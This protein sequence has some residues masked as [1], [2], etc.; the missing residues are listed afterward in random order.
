MKRLN[1]K[2]TFFL[3]SYPTFH[4]KPLTGLSREMCRE[5][6]PMPEVSLSES[7]PFGFHEALR[8]G[9]GVGA[10]PASF[11]RR[12]VSEYRID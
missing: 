9:E 8:T 3:G 4:A 10:A 1:W 11:S 12:M 5:V 7:E 2:G 6:K